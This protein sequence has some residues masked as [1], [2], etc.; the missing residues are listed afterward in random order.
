MDKIDK[1]AEAVAK[2]VGMAEQD[3]RKAIE[4]LT[5]EPAP[6]LDVFAKADNLDVLVVLN[7]KLGNKMYQG[8]AEPKKVERRHKKNKLARAS[9]KR[10]RK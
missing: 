4:T 2:N 10:N 8:T 3:V 5:E 7:Q 1:V 6:N 9:R